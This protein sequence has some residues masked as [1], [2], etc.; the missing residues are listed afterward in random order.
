LREQQARA[1]V[2]VPF[3]PSQ[4]WWPLLLEQYQSHQV[5]VPIVPATALFRQVRRGGPTHPLGGFACPA[6]VVWW[7]VLL[8]GATHLG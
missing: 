8:D 4:W 5:L 1:V 7:G 2:V 3:W 6:A